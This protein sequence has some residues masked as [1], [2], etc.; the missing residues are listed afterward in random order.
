MGE[1]DE[2]IKEI[3]KKEYNENITIKDA[4]KLALKIFKKFLGKEFS[5]E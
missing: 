5:Y 2:K 3:L 1:N 4:I